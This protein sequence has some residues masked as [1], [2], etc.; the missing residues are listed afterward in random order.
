[1]TNSKPVT[2]NKEKAK[3]KKK[4][5]PLRLNLAKLSK[6]KYEDEIL[7]GNDLAAYGDALAG[8]KAA[9]NAIKKTIDDAEAILKA[10]TLRHYCEH[11][12]QTGRAPDVRMFESKLGS[13]QVV[14]QSTAKVTMEK[15]EELKGQGIDL[16]QFKTRNSYTIRMA[17]ASKSDTRKIIESMQGILGEDF[18][19]VVSEYVHVDDEFFD[20]FDDIV[21]QSLGP[22]QRLDEKMLEVLRVLNPT[23]QFRE[24]STDLKEQAGYDLALEFSHVSAERKKAAKEAARRVKAEAADEKRRRLEAQ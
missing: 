5:D 15:A 7:S 4:K 14:Q 3:A 22:G 16:E 11:Y 23:I 8:A 24:F 10:A 6:L 17:K 9:M 21:K 2:N 12:A 1:M 20:N 18:P 13:F 19:D